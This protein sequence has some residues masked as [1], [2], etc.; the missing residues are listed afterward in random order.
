MKGLLVFCGLLLITSTGQGQTKGNRLKDPWVY[1]A[2]DK[3]RTEVKIFVQFI[4]EPSGKI[5]DDSVKALT[6]FHGLEKVAEK[7]VIDAPDYKYTKGSKPKDKNQKFVIP[8]VFT[9]DNFTPKEWSEFHKIKGQKLLEN[10]DKNGAKRELEE[11]IKLN[12]KN[13]ESYYILGQLWIE[14]DKSKSDKYFEQA[15]KYGF[16]K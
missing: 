3:G 16:Q 2:M 4:M 7:S 13:G 9:F 15:T 8:I 6:S 11:S 12:K 5:P 10:G 1:E 14:E